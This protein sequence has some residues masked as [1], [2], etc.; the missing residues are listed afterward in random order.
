MHNHL[1][2]MLSRYL[3]G[4]GGDHHHAAAMASRRRQARV[5]PL[6]SG[7]VVVGQLPVVL[8]ARLVSGRGGQCSGLSGSAL[9]PG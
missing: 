9:W 3:V 4:V 7:T 6:S 5:D 2:D 8:V 1:L